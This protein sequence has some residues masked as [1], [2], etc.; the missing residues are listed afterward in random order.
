MPIRIGFT[1]VPSSGK[2]SMAMKCAASCRES[3]KIVELVSEYARMYRIKYGEI[4][5]VQDQ[6]KILDK[7][8]EW[9]EEISPQTD[10]MVTDSPI[11][12]G[13]LYALDL[14]RNDSQ[15]DTM[16]LNDLF[17]KMCKYNT[18]LRYDVIFHLPPR[19]VVDDSVRDKV[20]LT[21]AWRRD[22]GNLMCSLFKKIFPA[23]NFIELQAANPEE[24]QCQ[25]TLLGILNM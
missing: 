24:V 11:F 10:I 12:L 7:Q 25:L 14:R 15:K 2:T 23:K 13:F 4:E 17:R 6:F 1:G 3:Y 21:E 19:E 8:L 20:H 16:W 22:A 18:P 5:T 9:E